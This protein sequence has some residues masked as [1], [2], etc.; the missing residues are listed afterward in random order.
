MIVSTAQIFY[1]PVFSYGLGLR[2]LF[3]LSFAHVMLE[4]PLNHQS[5]MGIGQSTRERIRSPSPLTA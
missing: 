5:F 4:F 3:F 2:W 1:A